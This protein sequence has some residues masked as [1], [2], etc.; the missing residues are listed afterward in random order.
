M[1]AEHWQERSTWNY[2]TWIY[3][4]PFWCLVNIYV[5]N[6]PMT[7]EETLESRKE[8]GL[9]YQEVSA[10][11]DF[12]T[13]LEA[14]FSCLWLLSQRNIK[15]LRP[16]SNDAKTQ[17][18]RDG[19]RIRRCGRKCKAGQAGDEADCSLRHAET[20]LVPSQQGHKDWDMKQECHGKQLER[21]RDVSWCR[22]S[23]GVTL[24]CDPHRIMTPTQCLTLI[25]LRYNYNIIISTDRYWTYNGTRPCVPP[26]VRAEKFDCNTPFII[27]H[28]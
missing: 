9:V 3:I 5:D 13:S 23:S 4:V 22:E 21:S 10:A 1:D 18:K 24:K 12:T 20:Q 26:S 17:C 28:K 19:P 7:T 11:S 6:V 8:D 27:G 25:Q 2:K 15:S 16:D 14:N